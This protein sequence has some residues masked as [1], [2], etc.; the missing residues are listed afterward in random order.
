MDR[1]I[2]CQTEG[3]IITNSAERCPEKPSKAADYQLPVDSF[4]ERGM[5]EGM[6][7]FKIQ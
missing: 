7:S 3:N 1:V 5:L 2:D 4:T 6:V